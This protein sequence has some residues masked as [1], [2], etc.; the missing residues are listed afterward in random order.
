MIT[1]D[2]LF[3]LAKEKGVDALQVHYVEN[4][5]FEIEVMNSDLEKYA[6][7]DTVSLSVKGIFNGKMGTVSTEVVDENLYES[8]VDSVISSAKTITNDEEVFIYEGDKEYKNLDYL[9]NHQLDHLSATEKIELTK[10]LERLIKAEDDRVIMVQSMYGDGKSIVRIENS[11]GLRLK[12]EVNGAFLGAIIIVSDGQDQRTNIEYKLTNDY[13]DF[14]LVQMAK[15][16]VSDALS[17][18]GASP[19]E[20][21][22]YEVL[23]TNKASS[24]LL[25]AHV[26]MFSAESVQKNVS[27]LKGK[28]GEVISSPLINLV[29]NPFLPK[30]SR[31]G[32]FDDEGV[33]T[34][35]KHLIETGKLVGYLH[36]LKT[37]KIDNTTS[38]GNGFSGGVRPTNFYIEPSQTTFDDAVKSMK[39]GLIVTQLDGTHAGCS[40]I[41]GDFSLQA[42]GFLVE[43][44]T[45]IHPVNLVTVAGNYLTLLKDV[46]MVC[47][48]LHFNFGFVGSPSLLISSLQVSGK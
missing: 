15:K 4:K 12:K 17:Q 2:K 31:S 43:N 30:S 35:E 23:L 34:K 39:K 38:T 41:S 32:S 10:E 33:A 24:S 27:L 36:N 21:G 44:G 25:S 48:D 11:R 1:F 7:S 47:N 5:D 3:D 29:D 8:L 28:V 42:S 40:P 9:F 13:D 37:A 18:L 16:G 46:K 45:I 6:I 26:S 20:S 22:E 14:D 19:V